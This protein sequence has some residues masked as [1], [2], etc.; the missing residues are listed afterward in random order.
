MTYR[1][2]FQV[3]DPDHSR[4]AEQVARQ[5]EAV[6]RRLAAV[7]AVVAVVS[8]KGGVGKSFTSAGLAL[9][10]TA[11]GRRVGVVDADLG[12]PTVAR[13]LEATGPLETTEDGVIPATGRGGI[14]VM[15]TEFLLRADQPLAWRGTRGGSHVW[16]GALEAGAVREFLADVAWGPLDLLLID[17]PPGVDGV[18]DLLELLGDRTLAVA[19]TIPTE[20]SRRSVARTI[21]AATRAGVRLLGVIEN[22]AGRRCSACGAVEPLFGGD[23]G[24]ALSAAFGIPVLA[25]IPFDARRLGD[26][27]PWQDIA[28][29]LLENAP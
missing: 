10:A 21:S 23:A 26:P 8:G 25:R 9:G 15:S 11:H 28:A 6:R 19:I 27:G 16:R 29:R 1:T 5:R 17:M 20:E 22:M 12:S 13:L 7:R 18:A 24:D 14:A 4:L 2:Y 3:T